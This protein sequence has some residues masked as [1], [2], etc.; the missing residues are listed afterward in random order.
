MSQSRVS[1]GEGSGN[2]T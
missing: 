2:K 1:E